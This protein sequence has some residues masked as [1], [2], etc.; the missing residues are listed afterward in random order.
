MKQQALFRK[1]AL[2]RLS[3]PEQ[4]DQLMHVTSPRGW[5]ALIALGLILFTGVLWSIFGVLPTKISG[6]GILIRAGGVFDV[7]SA[8]AGRLIEL[9]VAPGDIVKKNQVIAK[10]AL[11]EL[12]EQVNHARAELKELEIQHQALSGFLR[13]DTT[14]Q[15]DVL[16]GQRKT[17]EEKIAGS[18]S[19]IEW[20]KKRIA[21]EEKLFAEG[22]ITEKQVLQTKDEYGM[23]LESI[24][25]AQNQLKQIAARDSSVRNQNQQQL[26]S[27][28]L[29]IADQ[30]RKAELLQYQ[31]DISSQV[32]S[33]YDGRILE[34]KV[35]Q[36]SLILVGTPIVSLELNEGKLQALLYMPAAEGKKV[37]P[38][39]EALISPTT[40]RRE[41]YGLILGKV[42]SVSSFPATSQGMMR[43]LG[44]ETL[45]HSLA[46]S[47]APLEIYA[48]LTPEK[49]TES[50]FQWS[51]RKG[52]PIKIYSGTLCDGMVTVQKQHPINLLIPY[53]RETLGI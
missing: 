41:E 16:A 44:N 43:M 34:V 35:D 1:A 45:V 40:V 31:L 12:L 14:F 33:P 49:E 13:K 3:S 15:A 32:T 5:L 24:T 36:G 19:R 7:V 27:S 4:L 52:P 25:E 22:V 53:L 18:N 26:S 37:H 47:G 10:I 23:F 50:G 6:K 38:G 30:K 48:E 46:A 11:P 28:E 29:R 20:F 9:E 39:M 51:S 21:A 8:G 2:E 42:K 17:N